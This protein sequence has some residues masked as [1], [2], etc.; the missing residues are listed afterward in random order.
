MKFESVEHALHYAAGN[1]VQIVIY[2]NKVIDVT[3]FKEKHPGGVETIDKHIGK[4]I[5][6]VFD[7]VESHQT[8]TA[9]RDLDQFTIGEIKMSKDNQPILSEVENQYEIDL[10]RGI[11]WQVFMKLRLKEYLAFIHDPKHMINPPEAI[12]FENNFL[13]FFTKTPWYVIPL[14]WGPVVFYYLYAALPLELPLSFFILFYL[15]GILL[16]TSTEYILHRFVFH[17]DEGVPDNSFCIMLH[18]LLHGIHHAFPM[19]R[20]IFILILDIVWYSLQSPPT[21]C[22]VSSYPCYN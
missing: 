14:L 18:F 21:P 10:K 6:L 2:Q 11:L 5:T 22:T 8:K 15:F 17:L 12:M 19:D 20:Y 13:E 9:I 16:W 7:K 3:E 1:D 4:D